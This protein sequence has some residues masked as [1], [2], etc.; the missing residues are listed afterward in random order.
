MLQIPCWKLWSRLRLHTGTY[1]TIS[2]LTVQKLLKITLHCK[3]CTLF[4]VLP[5]FLNCSSS[6]AGSGSYINLYSVVGIN[7]TGS[8]PLLQ[9]AFNTIFGSFLAADAFKGGAGA[10]TRVTRVYDG[11]ACASNGDWE[12][13]DRLKK[14]FMTIH[15][16]KT[17]SVFSYALNN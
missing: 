8:A 5:N 17:G 13:L 14:T 1:C 6:W 4:K 7:H 10:N 9:A 11:W 12:Q 15:Y 16:V 3:L 2:V